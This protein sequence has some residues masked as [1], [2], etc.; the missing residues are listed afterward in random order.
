MQE[1]AGAGDHG[2][3]DAAVAVDSFTLFHNSPSTLANGHTNCHSNGIHCPPNHSPT[4]ADHLPHQ[5]IDLKSSPE[6]VISAGAFWPPLK[7][8]P[9]ANFYTLHRV[10]SPPRMEAKRQ[11]EVHEIPRSETSSTEPPNKLL[12]QVIRTPGRQP[13]PQ[14]THLSVPGPAQPKMLQEEDSGYVAPKFEGKDLQ[15]DQG[16][17]TLNEVDTYCVFR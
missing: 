11:N 7:A 2:C 16:R 17:L 15:M 8:V 1:R 14:P 3:G 10:P 6:D 13:S 12:E 4:I 9:L 5:T